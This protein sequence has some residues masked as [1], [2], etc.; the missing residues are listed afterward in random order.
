MSIIRQDF[1]KSEI[2]N[3]PIISIICAHS[4]VDITNVFGTFMPSS[5]LGG[6]TKQKF[7]EP[8]G[9]DFFVWYFYFLV[10]I[11]SLFTGSDYF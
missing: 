5:S 11:F 1:I 3:A 2:Q 6:R 8:K 4:E 9:E 7:S 10:F